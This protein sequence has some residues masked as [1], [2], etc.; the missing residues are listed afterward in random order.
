MLGIQ[1]RLATHNANTLPAVLLLQSLPGVL[2][3]HP[4]PSTHSRSVRKNCFWWHLEEPGSV[5]GWKE[6]ELNLGLHRAKPVSLPPSLSCPLPFLTKNLSVP[7]APVPACSPALTKVD[8]ASGSQGVG[9]LFVPSQCGV[10]VLRAGA[11]SSVPQNEE[12]QDSD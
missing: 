10:G 2:C 3:L 7:V 9:S 11:S 12:P 8:L 1:T 6:G 4:V 5:V